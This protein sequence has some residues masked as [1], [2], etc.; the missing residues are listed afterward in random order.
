MYYY[1]PKQN[2]SPKGWN[3]YIPNIDMP[4]F[5]LG[6]VF[7]K[8]QNLLNRSNII[9]FSNTGEMFYSYIGSSFTDNNKNRVHIGGSDTNINFGSETMISND[10]RNLFKRPTELHFDFENTFSNG[11]AYVLKDLTVYQD[12]KTS[13]INW[14]VRPMS[15]KNVYSTT[16]IPTSKMIIQK[17]NNETMLSWMAPLQFNNHRT[18]VQ[19]YNNT[20]FIKS[21]INNYYNNA[22]NVL[23]YTPN[24]Y[25]YKIWIPSFYL[26]TSST[27]FTRNKLLYIG[28]AIYLPALLGR[29]RLNT[30]NENLRNVKIKSNMEIIT[31]D[32]APIMLISS[33][34][35]LE[36]V[37]YIFNDSSSSVQFPLNNDEVFTGN[38]LEIAYYITGS[39]QLNITINEVKRN[40][41]IGNLFKL[42]LNY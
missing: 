33:N 27:L 30:F 6:E 32:N 21:Q 34:R 11:Y 17:N 9:S 15:G 38:P 4:F 25:D 16:F 24:E 7:T 36:N 8:D 26:Q 29:L 37:E 19:G 3:E 41:S 42:N 40:S 23:G 10:I 22:S 35:F 28:E 5:D 31:K 2:I 20:D 14:E 12:V 18:N 39:K 1:T 13:H